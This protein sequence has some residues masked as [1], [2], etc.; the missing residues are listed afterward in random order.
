M[1]TNKKMG[2]VNG[3][4]VGTGGVRKSSR[5]E[6]LGFQRVTCRRCRRLSL[7]TSLTK[8]IKRRKRPGLRAL[9]VRA[10]Q[11]VCALDQMALQTVVQVAFS[12]RSGTLRSTELGR[13]TETCSP[14]IIVS[15]P[16]LLAPKVVSIRS[17]TRRPR[18]ILACINSIVFVQLKTRIN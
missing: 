8:S 1:L 17:C 18:L 2:R 7:A 3:K 5:R 13:V 15:E 12:S 6:K 4:M 9:R 10:S 16:S 14:D 11:E